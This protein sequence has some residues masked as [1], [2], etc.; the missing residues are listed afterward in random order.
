MYKISQ[1]LAPF[2]PT[3]KNDT[4]AVPFL[5]GVSRSHGENSMKILISILATLLLTA[6]A[7]YSGSGLRPGEA[8]LE[9]VLRVMGEPAMRWQD[10][11]GARQLAYPRSIHTFMVQIGPDGKMQR[12]ENVMDMKTFPR[13][14]PGMTKS[15]VLRILGP[16]ERSATAY[17]KARDELVWEWRYC[18]EWNETARF[19]VLFDGSTETVRSTQSQT[20]SQMG[21]CGMDGRCVCG[22]AQ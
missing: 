11:D 7:A 21:L 12:I 17:F 1:V 6:C 20:E 2:P 16:S 22:H 18:D 19:D 14:R 15:E 4:L 3:N 8:R 5:F 13:I 9:D 10:P